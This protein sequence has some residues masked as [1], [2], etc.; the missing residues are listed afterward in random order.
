MGQI[1]LAGCARIALTLAVLTGSLAT[2]GAQGRDQRGGQPGDFDFYV[3]ALSW[4]PGFCELDGDRD[5]NR[6][7]CGEGAGLRFVVHGLWPQNERGFPSDCGPA[8]RTPSRIALDQARGLFPSE[9][10]ARHQWRKH[11]TCSGSSPSDYFADTRRAREKIVIPPALAKAERDQ[12]WTAIDL[13]R[14]FVAANP[15]LRTDMMSVACRRGVLQEVR[16]CLSKDLRDFRMCQE[17]DR[18]G[19]RTRDITV[20]APR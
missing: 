4:S 6:E 15:G 1:S 14:A 5:R 17:V 8:G 16:I 20:N 19:C 13:E 9:G 11:G 2:A 3:L 18:S 7:Q 12:S 10:L